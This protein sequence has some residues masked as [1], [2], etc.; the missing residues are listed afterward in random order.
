M[1]K[2]KVFIIF[3]NYSSVLGQG[4]ENIILRAKNKKEAIKSFLDSQDC[5]I[6]FEI[7]E[8]YQISN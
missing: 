8:I 6:D 7:S 5:R 2:L 3:Y 1:T 4:Y